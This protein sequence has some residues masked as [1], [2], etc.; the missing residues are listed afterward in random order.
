MSGGAGVGCFLFVYLV[1]VT[2][3]NIC[4]RNKYPNIATF[5]KKDTFSK[6]SFLMFGICVKFWELNLDSDVSSGMETLWFD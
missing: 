2:C 1:T 5:W 3:C 6:L 4:L